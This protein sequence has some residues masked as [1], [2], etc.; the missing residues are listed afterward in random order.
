MVTLGLWIGKLSKKST[1]LSRIFWL[2]VIIIFFGVIDLAT[3]CNLEH[4]G[5]GCLGI[6]IIFGIPWGI[7]VLLLIS[8]VLGYVVK[9]IANPIEKKIKNASSIPGPLW[10][11]IFG[12]IVVSMIALNIHLRATFV[13]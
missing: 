10:V 11:W 9:I 4:G 12:M 5:M 6:P 1:A 2:I 7:A 13:R 8:R 3:L